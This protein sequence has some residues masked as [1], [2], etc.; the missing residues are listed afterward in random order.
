MVQRRPAAEVLFIEHFWAVAYERMDDANMAPASRD[1]Q[2]C[3]SVLCVLPADLRTRSHER[4]YD[5]DVASLA[6]AAEG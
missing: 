6:G 4:I 2:G 3:R 5:I 1:V